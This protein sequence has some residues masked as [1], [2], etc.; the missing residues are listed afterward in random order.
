M[1]TR[2]RCLYRITGW[3][4]DC[5]RWGR[6]PSLFLD[7]LG[8]DIPFWD[9]DIDIVVATHPDEDHILGLVDAL[10]HYEVNL[11]L[12]NGDEADES[13]G[14]VALLEEAEKQQTHV[15]RALAGEVIELGDG[16]R[17]EIL[18]PG[19]EL[20]L[21]EL[22]LKYCSFWLP[23]FFEGTRRHHSTLRRRALGKSLSQVG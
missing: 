23:L 4:A 11:L 19:P 22:K 21:E 8:L 20:D 5:G 6:Y 17:L 9:K 12:V 3:A 2:G 14:Y 18:H 15:R 16:V 13:E 7:K 1:W 10:E